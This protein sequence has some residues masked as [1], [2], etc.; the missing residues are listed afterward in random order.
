MSQEEIPSNLGVFSPPWRDKK[1]SGELGDEYGP[2]SPATW[3]RHLEQYRNWAWRKPS[4]EATRPES[5]EIIAYM[6]QED[7]S[8]RTD[9]APRELEV[10]QYVYEKGH[11]FRWVAR[12]LSIRRETVRVY[13]RRLLQ[14]ARVSGPR[15]GETE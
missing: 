8:L 13:A 9:V 11:S 6:R 2:K 3:A 1:V 7:G 4:N 10:Y 15:K 5:L 12:R 14:K